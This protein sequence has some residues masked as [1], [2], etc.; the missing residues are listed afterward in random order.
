[1][2]PPSK[3]FAGLISLPGLAATKNTRSSLKI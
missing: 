2:M 1:M 3:Q